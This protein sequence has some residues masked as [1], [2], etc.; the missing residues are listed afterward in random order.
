[1]AKL[2]AMV[3]AMSQVDGR[4]RKTID[5][6]TRTIREAG[7]ITT[8]KRGSGAAE[9]TVPEVVNL[10]IAMNAAESAREAPIE[11]DRYRSLRQIAEIGKGQRGSNQLQRYEEYPQAIK[12]VM[13]VHTFGEALETLV[14]GVPSLVQWSMARC[15][16]D[17]PG[18]EFVVGFALA[19]RARLFGIDVVFQRYT[20][21]IQLFRDVGDD[22]IVEFEANFVADDE[23]AEKGFYG[24]IQERFLV[25]RQVSVK[26]GIVT[27]LSAWNVLHPSVEIEGVPEVALKMNQLLSGDGKSTNVDADNG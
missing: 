25:D 23:R 4:E 26:I 17:F 10:I 3:T 19:L 2:P 15:E 8:G 13:D 9:M 21:K 11:I 7:Y 5:H 18:A 1:M 14:E 12:D 22:R 16:E 6:I 20:P 27:L 24:T